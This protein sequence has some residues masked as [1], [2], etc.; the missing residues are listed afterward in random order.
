[1][2]VAYRSI[3]L[4]IRRRQHPRVDR[5]LFR[6]TD[7]QHLALLNRAQ[8]LGLRFASHLRNFVEEDRS[9][10][11][12]LKKSLLSAVRAGK[13]AFFMTKQVAL[14]QRVWNR[15]TVDGN[16]WTVPARGELVDELSRDLFSGSA[17]AGDQDRCIG[18]SD[19]FDQAHDP[20]RAPR[21]LSRNEVESVD[22]KGD[23]RCEE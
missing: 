5:Y 6:T 1:M 11:S 15:G 9:P 13:S 21:K 3:D 16:V 8:E 2:S 22:R 23:G 7:G 18:G 12:T 10:V 20:W 14:D 4:S 19:A 17:F